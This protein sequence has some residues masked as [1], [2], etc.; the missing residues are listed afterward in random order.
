MSE[1]NFERMEFKYRRGIYEGN[2]RPCYSVG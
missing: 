2:R 1:E